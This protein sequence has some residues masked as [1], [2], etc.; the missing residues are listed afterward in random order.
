MRTLKIKYPATCADCH[1]KHPP[2]TLMEMRYRTRNSYDLV[3]VSKPVLEKKEIV[4]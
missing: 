3:C 4:K 1:M 2:G